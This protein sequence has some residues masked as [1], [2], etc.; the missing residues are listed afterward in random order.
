[1][2]CKISGGRMVFGC[3]KIWGT[4]RNT[5]RYNLELLTTHTFGDVPH[6]RAMFVSFLCGYK[7]VCSAIR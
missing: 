4:Q 5:Y 7:H 2:N 3:V 1:M 6:R